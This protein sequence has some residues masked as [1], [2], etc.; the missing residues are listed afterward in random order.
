MQ[1]VRC[2]LIK[3]NKY[4]KMNRE[5]IKIYNIDEDK[6]IRLWKNSIFV[7]DSSALLDF[8][9]LPKSKR[10]KIYNEIFV[11]LENKLWIPYHVEYEFLKNRENIITKP[12]K[13]KYHPIKDKIK[14]LKNSFNK[15]LTKK[16]DSVVRETEKDD[17]H[18]HFEQTELLKFKKE[19]EEFE[20][21][22]TSFQ[23]IILKDIEKSE[24]EVIACKEDDDVLEN[25]EKFFKV[26]REFSFDEIIKIV[27]EG[28]LRYEFKIPPGYGDYYKQEKK[29]I[30]IFGDL[31]L[32]KQILE[33][34]KEIKLPIIF[35]TNDIKKDEDWCYLDHKSTE[36]RILSPR[37]EL[38]KEIY[39]NSTVEFWMYNL[40]QFLY[41][42]NKH[43][44]SDIEEETIQNLFKFL[45]D[46]DKNENTLKFKCSNCGKIHQ[47]D[48][49]EIEL[50][51]ECVD[52]D[53]RNM[54]IE[55]HYE[56]IVDF[57]CECDNIIEVIFEIWEYPQGVH[58]YDDITISNGKLLQSFY[59]TNDFFEDEYE[60]E[61]FRCM[62]CEGDRDGFGN[63]I[64]HWENIRI[65]NQLDEKDELKN[66]EE[67]NVGECDWCST[68]HFDCP[69]CGKFTYA[70]DGDNEC[71]N[72]C[73]YKLKIED[74]L[75]SDF[76]KERHYVF[77]K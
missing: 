70:I 49:E 66:I 46:K 69:N 10:L 62:C 65:D 60:G 39:N 26:G 27:E 7:F 76:F 15:E 63:N 44:Q 74:K 56:A 13:E 16:V 64:S 12:L 41:Y 67:I 9:F 23:T 37:E 40:P 3:P 18:P 68:I 6:E 36:D 32:W 42:A 25:L 53:E 11:K 30:Q 77:H 75:N 59:F 51:F 22:I 14:E 71:P 34:S 57:E 72:Q 58:N 2:N 24:N 35:I 17:K 1:N 20:K 45:N 21:K 28:K 55:N 29:G 31:I 61:I 19:I 52:S 43:L 33:F 5:N 50:D 38:I 4:H 73:G 48:K 8:Y 47:F 54:G